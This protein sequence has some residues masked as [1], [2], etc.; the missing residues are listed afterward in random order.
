MS[1]CVAAPDDG[2]AIFALPPGSRD[3]GCPE[4]WT[5]SMER[6][7]QRRERAA[8][9]QRVMRTRKA[10]MSTA[11][12]AAT[13]L[14]PVSTTAHAWQNATASTSTGMLKK[15][16][17]GPAVAAAQRALGIAADGIFGPATKR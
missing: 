13:L 8:A 11:V 4:I 5:R 16:S 14:A 15:G 1:A 12:I 17:R 7:R 10:R 3:L 2:W 6:S 9:T